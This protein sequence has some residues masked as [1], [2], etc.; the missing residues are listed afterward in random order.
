M[1]LPGLGERAAL[2]DRLDADDLAAR[3]AEE[4][5]GDQPEQAEADDDHAL[6]ELRL[7]AAHAL[8]RDRAQRGEG[9]VARV[10]PG[11]TGATRLAGTETIS[12][13]LA[14]PTP[15]QATSWPSS[16]SG[17]PP[18]STTTPAHE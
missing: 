5:D 10:D 4:L 7:G 9:G 16:S 1:S 8:H 18:V 3:G 17:M 12:A 2:G 13:W 15:A 14:M 11:G 6:A